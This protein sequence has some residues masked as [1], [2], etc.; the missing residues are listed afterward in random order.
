MVEVLAKVNVNFCIL[1][2]GFS[3][4]KVS[5]IIFSLSPG[6]GTLKYIK[7][8]KVVDTRSHPSWQ[9]W[10]LLFTCPIKLSSTRLSS[11]FRC[12]AHAVLA[13]QASDSFSRCSGFSMYGFLV[14]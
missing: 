11:R 13:A 7:G 3:G 5:T 1:L 12:N 9:H 10:S 6:I 8:S 2:V 4:T 14:T